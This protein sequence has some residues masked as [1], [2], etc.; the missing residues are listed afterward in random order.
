MKTV[1]ALV[2]QVDP[3]RSLLLIV[4]GRQARFDPVSR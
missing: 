2:M 1:M 3:L 4:Q